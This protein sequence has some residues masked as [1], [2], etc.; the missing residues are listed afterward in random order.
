MQGTP[1]SLIVL[2][3]S[4]CGKW[5]DPIIN[6]CAGRP[7][8]IERSIPIEYVFVKD[9]KNNGTNYSGGYCWKNCIFDNGYLW[10]PIASA[11]SVRCV[12]SNSSI[13]DSNHLSDSKNCNYVNISSESFGNHY[14]GY[15][16]TER[17]NYLTP[18]YS[19]S[20]ENKYKYLQ[21]N[22]GTPTTVT[23]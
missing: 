14:Y 4:E 1:D 7:K 21:S 22:H 9:A 12:F 23:F 20:C 3:C 8:E 6:T 17:N 2:D 16:R 19:S 10:T 18:V 5:E 11:W 15:D 13:S